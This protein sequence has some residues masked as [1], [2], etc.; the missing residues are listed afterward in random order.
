MYTYMIFIDV[1]IVCKWSQLKSK[2][3]K[4]P[5]DGLWKE[6]WIFS[7]RQFVFK[8]NVRAEDNAE[9]WDGI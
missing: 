7:G 4:Q 8:S 5:F 3:N 9:I 2:Q 1:V 6:K